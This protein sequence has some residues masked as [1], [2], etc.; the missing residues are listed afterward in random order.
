MLHIRDIYL[1]DMR[2]SDGNACRTSFWGDAW[3][4][5]SHLKDKF[6]DLYN[7]CNEKLIIVA[8]A[9]NLG[10][11]LSFKRWLSVDLQEQWCAL[12]IFSIRV[13]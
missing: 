11:R 3:C 1:C 7:I 9:K 10:C 6:P 12:L 8:A 4:G 2:M 5:N 13:C